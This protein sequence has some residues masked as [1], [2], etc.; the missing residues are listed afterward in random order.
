MEENGKEL[1]SGYRK[2]Q[3][4]PDNKP[5]FYKMKA[6]HEG[7]IIFKTYKKVKNSV[8]YDIFTEDGEFVKQIKQSRAL[9]W[10]VFQGD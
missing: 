10:L 2:N 8:C 3:I 4:W 5:H 6:D 1:P 7:Y 9:Y